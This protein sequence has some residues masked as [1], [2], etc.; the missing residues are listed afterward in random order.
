MPQLA[1]HP[2]A[3][4]H[5]PTL[6]L[7]RRSAKRDELIAA[8]MLKHGIAKRDAQGRLQANVDA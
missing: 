2:A 5:T 7:A 1:P 6:P 4:T 8:L 3:F